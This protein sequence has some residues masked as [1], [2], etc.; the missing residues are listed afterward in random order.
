MSLDKSAIELLQV[1]AALAIVTE[2]TNATQPL[3]PL[4]AVPDGISIKSLENHMP[5][6]MRFRGRMQTT[7]LAEF[8]QY[9]AGRKYHGE[10]HCFV[11]ADDMEA[12]HIFN[13][14]N[15]QVAGHCDDTASV[16]LDRT[17]EYKALLQFSGSKLLQRDFAEFIEDWSHLITCKSEDGADVSLAK[18]ISAIRRITVTAGVKSES[19]QRNFST[20][21]SA[22]ESISINAE[23]SLPAEIHFRCSPYIGLP[24]TTFEL[25]VAA[26]TSK[27]QPL[28]IARIKRHELLQQEFANQ[29]SLQLQT[30]FD[31]AK[32]E[33][34]VTIGKFSVSA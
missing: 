30:L 29:F 28:L 21:R 8:V 33:L 9:I 15:E 24:E 26:L 18:A 1:A 14:G 16:K 23:N 13:Y 25:R 34:P 6:R 2:S 32:L 7:L 31:D 3:M 10:M 27:D 5:G 11:N 20:E 12:N 19:E 4:V 17:A 22:L